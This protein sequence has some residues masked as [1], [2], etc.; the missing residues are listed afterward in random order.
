MCETRP[1][2]VANRE[3]A[4][5]KPKYYTADRTS[6]YKTPNLQWLISIIRTHARL[7]TIS[8]ENHTVRKTDRPDQPKPGRTPFDE[9]KSGQKK[10]GGKHRP[11]KTWS[12]IIG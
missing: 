6:A 8:R 10:S 4:L 5:F 9:Q 1:H 7:G 2:H 11:A 3:S 12:L